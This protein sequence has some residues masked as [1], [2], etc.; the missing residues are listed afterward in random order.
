MIALFLVTWLTI[1]EGE[2]FNVGARSGSATQVPITGTPE[3]FVC[4]DSAPPAKL[5]IASVNGWDSCARRSEVRSRTL[6][7][8][9]AL[10]A[11][12]LLAGVARGA[13]QRDHDSH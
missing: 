13:F 3:T 5:V 9:G 1:P 8:F 6:V 2:M 4:T 11:V 12:V 10:A 7:G